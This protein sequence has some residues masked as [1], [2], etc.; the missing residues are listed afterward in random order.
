MTAW[1]TSNSK[2]VHDGIYS[3]LSA[4][5]VSILYGCW[6]VKGRYWGLA[7]PS[8]G[9]ALKNRYIGSA[10]QHKPWR[11]LTRAEFELALL[12]L[13]DSLCRY[14]MQIR[15]PRGG[16]WQMLYT[17]I[18][19]SELHAYFNALVYPGHDKRALRYPDGQPH[20]KMV[21]QEIPVKL[22]AQGTV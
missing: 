17:E 2:P 3:T 9:T 5:G 19:P 6:N 20:L 4:D 18:H 21:Y 15:S 16:G 11:G 7:Q 8:I 22:T 14:E 12:R 10:I 13:P 1:M